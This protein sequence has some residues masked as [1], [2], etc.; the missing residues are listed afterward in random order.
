MLKNDKVTCLTCLPIIS[1]LVYVLDVSQKS[2][3]GSRRVEDD[4]GIVKQLYPI[5]RTILIP[6]HCKFRTV[7]SW[8]SYVISRLSILLNTDRRSVA[9]TLKSL[10]LPNIGSSGGPGI[11]LKEA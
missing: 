11:L 5:H 9:G 3:V 7:Y 4:F 6:T 2:L 10:A 1:A 8:K